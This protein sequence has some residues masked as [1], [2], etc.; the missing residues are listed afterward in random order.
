[1]DE[2]APIALM[3]FNRPQY[4]QAVI[5][6]L[7]AQRPHGI[8]G[9][10]VHLFQDG[11]VNRYSRMR[12][13]KDADIQASI[14][15]F[16]REIPDGTVHASEVNIGIAENFLRAERYIFEER[17]LECAWFFED[18]LV[19]SPAYFQ[20]M[21]RLQTYARAVGNIAYFAAYG[22]H[23]LS[24][25]QLQE[26]KKSLRGLDH[27]W[28]FGVLRRP[29]LQM[30]PLLADFYGIVVG[31]DYSRRD[32]RAVYALYGAMDISPRGSSQ[33]AAKAIACTRLGVW[34]CNTCLPFAKYIG[35]TGQHMTPELF[36]QLGFDSVTASEEEVTDIYFP[37]TP[38]IRE[39]I[40]EQKRL[41]RSIRETE[42]EGLVGSL[43]AR[44]LN[45]MRPNTR[46]DVD[47]LYFLLLRRNVESEAIYQAY[48]GAC[49]VLV[50]VKAILEAAEF[51]ALL[52]PTA[53]KFT[54][55]NAVSRR[56]C[57]RDDIERIFRLLVSRDPEPEILQR[58]EGCTAVDLLLQ[59]VCRSKE[60]KKICD[61]FE[62]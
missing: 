12:Y 46:E 58:H 48:V 6:S 35:Q 29:W 19:L 1:M 60:F 41:F 45:P 24:P 32:H 33:D 61:D 13:A 37:P 39:L 7:K 22:D 57:T 50:L 53:E 20:M 44:E 3:S 59:G 10:E 11:A 62:P 28:G 43:P 25:E 51:R 56:A 15:L 4:L 47:A 18:D 8:H 14:E 30:Q 36:A 26:S 23:Y 42:F 52:D 31:N 9:R 16:L 49:S 40:R 38:E 55:R 2:L 17:E 54:F 27:H 5:A 34:R 21:T